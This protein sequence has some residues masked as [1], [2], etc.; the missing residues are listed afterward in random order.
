MM[1]KWFVFMLFLSVQ[2]SFFAQE[3]NCDVVINTDK[4]SSA[5]TRTFDALEKSVRDFMNTTSFTGEKYT[6]DQKVAC[7]VTLQINDYTNNMVS[8]TL[9]VG[10]SRIVYG[11]T[12]QSPLLLFKEDAISFRYIEYEP[13]EYSLNSFTTELA[14][15]LSFYAHI[16]IGLDQDSFKR[17][18]GQEQLNNAMTIL[19]LAQTEGGE[20]W[21]QGKKT[22]S[23]YYLI[24][25]LLSANYSSFREALYSYHRLGM[26]QLAENPEMAK[27]QIFE[28]IQQLETAYK[29]KPNNL[30]VR[31]FF[32]AK[33]N[34]VV[35]IFSAG[36]EFDKKPLI[37]MLNK[38]NPTNGN[39]WYRM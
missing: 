19:N 26:D 9:I 34:E 14:A 31:L 28:A 32:D 5:N 33:A 24:N 35:N 21:K 16:F 15:T 13:I 1:K 37:D 30:L 7:Y 18:G 29:V 38:I 8:A 17:N 36:P 10:S 27:K 2:N 3:L 25:D 12:Y 20:A 11:S 23:R 39:K 6:N 4:L 22:V